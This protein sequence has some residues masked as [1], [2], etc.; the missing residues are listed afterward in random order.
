MGIGIWIIGVSFVVSGRGIG[1]W[2]IGE[3]FTVS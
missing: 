3:D 1:Y 2:Q